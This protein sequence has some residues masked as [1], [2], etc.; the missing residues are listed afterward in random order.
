MAVFRKVVAAESSSCAAYHPN[1]PAANDTAGG[2]DPQRNIRLILEVAGDQAERIAQVGADKCHH[3][4]GGDCDKRRDQA[5]FDRGNAT[6][7]L[8]QPADNRRSTGCQQPLAPPKDDAEGGRN[9]S[10][11]ALDLVEVRGST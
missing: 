8:R 10:F 5:V 1:L 7:V 2:T 3:D 6:F 9:P 11:M 4:D